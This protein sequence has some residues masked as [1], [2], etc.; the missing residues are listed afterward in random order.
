MLKGFEAFL[1]AHMPE[2]ACG[3]AVFFSFVH[4]VLFFMGLCSFNVLAELASRGHPSFGAL[5]SFVVTFPVSWYVFISL[6]RRLV[7]VRQLGVFWVGG[8]GGWVL[9]VPISFFYHV[10][11]SA[12]P[13]SSLHMYVASWG[14]TPDTVF[15]LILCSAFW[16]LGPLVMAYLAQRVCVLG[17]DNL[18][19][20]V[21]GVLLAVLVLGGR[22][23][24]YEKYA[25]E[26][27]LSV[28]AANL[29][30]GGNAYGEVVAYESR[31]GVGSNEEDIPDYEKGPQHFYRP[32]DAR[33]LWGTFPSAL[34]KLNGDMPSYN[35][36]WYENSL[37]Y[38]TAGH[39]EQ[40]YVK[41][42]HALHLATQD[43]FCP[44]HVFDDAHGTPLGVEMD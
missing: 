26:T 10:I 12:W 37:N 25:H 20:G 32:T 33:G 34:Y 24:C 6:S 9:G 44:P 42:G 7:G 4:A 27:V 43:M 23:H 38:Y 29:L 31:L 17:K 35:S 2:S 15:I 40:A 16:S 5:S 8:V 21:G 14:S 18:G 30:D 28:E 19:A 3:R 41:L 39:K 11:L 22:A 36:P 13:V 1:R